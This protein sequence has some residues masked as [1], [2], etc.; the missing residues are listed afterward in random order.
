MSLTTGEMSAAD[1]AAVVGNRNDGGFGGF[2]DSGWWIILLFL[3][4][5]NGGWG[6]GFGG[7]N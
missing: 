6:N 1:L 3:L 7:G 4:L 2:G 5:G